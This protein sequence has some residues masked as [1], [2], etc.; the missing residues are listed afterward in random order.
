[1][2]SILLLWRLE[3]PNWFPLVKI[4]ISRT[5]HCLEESSFLFP[6]PPSFSGISLLL[7][8]PDY[9]VSFNLSLVLC[10]PLSLIHKDPS[11]YS[12]SVPCRAK[13]SLSI[14]RSSFSKASLATLSSLHCIYNFFEIWHV[15][16]IATSQIQYW[17]FI[18]LFSLY[19]WVSHTWIQ[20]HGLKVLINLYWTWFRFFLSLFC[21]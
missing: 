4:G 1:M 16:S 8:F 5:I 15:F 9:I 11:M 12:Y 7:A 18:H 2:H 21:K 19:L 20:H 14:S 3:V 13:A 10:L 17:I 6:F